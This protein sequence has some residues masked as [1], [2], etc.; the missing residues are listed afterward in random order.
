MKQH[1]AEGIAQALLDGE[2]A[3]AERHAAEAHLAACPACA[4]EQRGLR[5]AQERM[6]TVL[7]EADA[8]APVAQ[9]Q[10]ALRRRAARASQA[11]K[12]RR[13]LLRAAVLV[14]GVAGA[15]TAAVA[16]PG[17]PIPGLI[18]DI[19]PGAKDPLRETVGPRPAPAPAALAE[20]APTGVSILPEAGSVRVVLSGSAPGLRVRTRLV[21]GAHAEVHASA[22]AARAR[23]RT[24]PGRIEVVGAGAGEVTV[25]LPRGARAAFVEVNGRVY[26]AKEGGSLRVMAPVVDPAASEPVFRVGG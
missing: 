21:D 10:M 18:T 22:A 16:V 20:D 6:R 26:V 1:L 9:A 12:G 4:A 8:P 15:A 2:L 24:S 17:S 3:G 13:A 25:S 23:F 19:L 5:S 11:A 7:A 14:L